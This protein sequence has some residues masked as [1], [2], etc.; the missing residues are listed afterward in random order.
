MRVC[1]KGELFLRI[2]MWKPNLDQVKVK[3]TF[4][5][6]QTMK[7]EKARERNSCTLFLTSA[8]NGGGG[9]Q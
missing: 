6:E 7:T 9:G 2:P 3:G 1:A 4:T 8:L 5:L